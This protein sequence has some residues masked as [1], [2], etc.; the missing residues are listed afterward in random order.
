MQYGLFL[1]A[2]GVSLADSVRFFRHG[3]AAKCDQVKFE[4]KGYLYSIRHMYGQEGRRHSYENYYDCERI[5]DKG[6]APKDGEF[7]GCPFKHLSSE[8]LQAFLLDE[9]GVPSAAAAGRIAR[10]AADQGRPRQACHA[11]FA[12]THPGAT[13]PP[14][15]APTHYP[16]SKHPNGHPNA[17]FDAHSH[18]VFSAAAATALSYEEEEEEEGE[19]GGGDGGR[20]REMGRESEEEDEL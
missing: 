11:C 13:K 4:K 16:R 19:G 9:V 6:A 2:A 1:K 8:H 7:H 18:H 14:G 5:I 17:W 10:V 3:Y 15:I 12:A 20:E